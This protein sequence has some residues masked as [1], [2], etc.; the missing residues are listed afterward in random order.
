M[1]L[2][3]RQKKELHK[4]IADHLHQCGFGETLN[5]FKKDAN[6]PGELDKKY[7]GLLEKKHRHQLI[8]HIKR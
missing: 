8:V 5:A 3:L 1:V 6:M 7:S 2:T 4:A